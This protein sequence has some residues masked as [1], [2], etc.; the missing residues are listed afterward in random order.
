METADA[1]LAAAFDA[2]C[3]KCSLLSREQ[4]WHFVEHGYVRIPAAFDKG[5]AAT[6]REQAWRDLREK[7]GVSEQNPSGWGVTQGANG[8][9]GYV[10]TAGSGRKFTLRTEAPRAFRALADVVGGAE[11]LPH[12]GERLAWGDGA[13]ANLGNGEPTA[14][15]SGGSGTEE[16]SAGVREGLAPR[17]REPSA[18]VREGFAPR[19]KKPSSNAVPIEARQRSWHKDG[20]HFRH[21]LDSPEQGLLVVPIY[22]DILPQ[23]GGTRIAT[24]SIAPVA[25]LLA[26][27]PQ[28]FHADSVQGAG[29]LIPGLVEQCSRFQEL[30]GETGDMAILHPY[31]LH[32]PCANPSTRPRFIANAALVL[33]EPMRFDRP[34]HETCSLVELA[35]LRALG[36]ARFPFAIEG[37]REAFVPGPFRDDEERAAQRTRLEAEMQAMAQRGVVT[38]DWGAE[39]G[40]MSNEPS[41]GVRE[42][43]APRM[44]K[45]SAP[46]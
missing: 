43:L 29:Y 13:I 16:P 34:R 26:S 17:M 30:T 36:T 14:P 2:A 9:P 22:S 39:F 35:V 15:S 19:M 21:F 25:R 31:M 41:A 44:K 8:I 11:R 38:P 32:R 10:R 3:S 20:W 42:G 24:D 45:T 23:S 18:G 33:A 12:G 40:Y 28:G 4:A 1:D 27:N 6:V 5:I 7:H 37:E 46:R